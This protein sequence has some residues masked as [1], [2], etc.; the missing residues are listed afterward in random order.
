MGF[1]RVMGVSVT[2]G[3]DD[4]TCRELL[5]VF[6]RQ[7]ITGWALVAEDGKFLKANPTFCRLLEYTE[8]E[9]KGKR[10]QDITDPADVQADV[11]MA[12]LVVE[13]HYPTYDMTKAYLTKTKRHLPVLL[14]VTGLRTSGRFIFFAGEIAPIDRPFPPPSQPEGM[15]ATLRRRAFFQ[16]VRDNWAQVLFVLGGIGAGVKMAYESIPH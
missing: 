2:L 6:W 5:E 9:L 7:S 11:E 13:G 16:F 14:R 15:A 10:F 12:R 4:E 3:L 1:G 8:S